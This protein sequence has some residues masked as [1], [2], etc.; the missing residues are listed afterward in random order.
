MY[1]LLLVHL[2]T[3]LPCF[4]VGFWIFATPKGTVLHKCLGRVFVTLVMLTAL[5]TLAMPAEVGPRLFGH[6][7]LIHGLSL[8]VLVQV[9]LAVIA[10]RRNSIRTHRNAMTGVYVGG[11][12]IAGILALAPGR[13]L[14]AWLFG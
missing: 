11:V 12:L 7:G 9:P 14:H 8:L 4:L 6:L 2:A 13:T 1:Y 3:V 10:I 5:V